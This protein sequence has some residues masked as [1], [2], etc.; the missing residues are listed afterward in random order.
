MTFAFCGQLTLSPE[1]QLE[2]GMTGIY[3]GCRPDLCKRVDDQGDFL[4]FDCF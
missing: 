4:E 1:K 3:S 2:M